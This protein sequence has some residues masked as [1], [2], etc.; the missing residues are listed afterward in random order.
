MNVTFRFFKWK[1]QSFFLMDHGPL[2]AVYTFYRKME[3]R[4]FELGLLLTD[5]E[6]WESPCWNT[7]RSSQWLTVLLQCADHMATVY[8]QPLCFQNPLLPC[9]DIRENIEYN[10]VVFTCDAGYNT[11]RRICVFYP[12]KNHSTQVIISSAFVIQIDTHK[13]QRIVKWKDTSSKLWNPFFVKAIT[14]NPFA[15]SEQKKIYLFVPISLFLPVLFSSNTFAKVTGGT[16][17]NCAH[18]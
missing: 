13:T 10:I 11:A 1:D 17:G 9:H 8:L 4:C 3:I 2:S 7:P 18:M 15:P 14:L 5:R 12:S 6:W 16:V